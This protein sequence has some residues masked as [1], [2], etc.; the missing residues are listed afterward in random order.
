M[1][2]FEVRNLCLDGNP[3]NMNLVKFNKNFNLIEKK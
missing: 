3:I 1:N 2:N